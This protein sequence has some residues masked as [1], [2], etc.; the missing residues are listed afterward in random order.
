MMIKGSWIFS[1][2]HNKYT[3]VGGIQ[4]AY[5]VGFLGEKHNTPF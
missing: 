4:K 5:R 3:K 1:I 2:F